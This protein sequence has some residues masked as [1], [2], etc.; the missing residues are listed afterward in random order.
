MARGLILPPVDRT[1]SPH[2]GWTRAHWVAVADHLLDSVLPY[3]TPGFA[4]IRLPGRA[5][6]SGPGSDGLEGYARTLLLAAFRIAGEQG[7]VA[8]ALLERYAE[9][10]AAGTDPDHPYAWPPLADHSQQLVEAASIALA[11]Q[12]TRPWLF[13][14]LAAPV[15]ARVVDWLAGFVGRRTPQSNWVLFQVVVEQF[16]AN[17]GGPHE[18]A[19]IERGLDLI[20]QWYAGDGWYSDGAGQNFD[21]YTGWA[22]HLYPVLWARMAADTGR[23]ER[24]RDRLGAFLEQ[25]QHCFAADGAPL[26]Q[27][28][29]LCYRFATVAPLWLGALAGTDALTPGRTRRIASGVLRHFVEHGVPDGRGLLTLGWYDTFLPCTQDYSG[30]ASPYWASKGMLGLLLPADHPVWTE[31]ERAAPIDVADQVVAL[32]APG[33]LLHGTR[34]DGVVRVL[35]HGSDRARR[36]PA[37]GLADPHYAK[38]GYATHTAPQT[39][40]DTVVAGVDGHLAVVAP[41][42]TVSRRLRIERIAVFDRFAA[43]AYTDDLPGGPV[44]VETAA[45]VRGAWE[46]RIHRVTAPA[47]H[48]VRDGGYALADTRPP[49]AEPATDDP[50]AGWVRVSRDDGLSSTVIALLGFTGVGVARAVDANAYG[51]CSATPYLVDPAHPG[52]TSTYVSMAVLSGDRVAPAAIRECVSVESTPDRTVLT[53]PDGERVVVTLGASPGYERQPPGGARISWHD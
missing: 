23:A 2:T 39:A 41:D 30:P 43:S 1:R 48:L 15:Q 5:S 20:E 51:P 45:V 25:Y 8:P 19:E 29:S 26:H 21:Y 37:N 4:Q 52:G 24:Y 40:E 17:V 42:G 31:P 3:A 47:G 28:R 32:P 44:R 46:V 6:R 7:A 16:L 53:F 50:A 13:D 14:R 12:E 10:L 11:L 27:G 33:W 34:H 36:L 49:V 38:L 18:P 9:G 22:M 35:N